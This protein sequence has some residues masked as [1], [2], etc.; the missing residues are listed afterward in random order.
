MNKRQKS[1][2][3]GKKW[4]FSNPSV[5]FL[6]SCLMLHLL[7]LQ[8]F[9]SFILSCYLPLADVHSEASPNASKM[10]LVL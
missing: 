10:H 3:Y 2:N 8:L 5:L 6:S 4:L 7:H 1:A 9:F